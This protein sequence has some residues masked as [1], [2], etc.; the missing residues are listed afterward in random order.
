MNE[1]NRFVVKSLPSSGT[2]GYYRHNFKK[3][4]QGSRLTVP[5]LTMVF[6]FFTFCGRPDLVYFEHSFSI[7]L[8]HKSVMSFKAISLTA[9]WRGRSEQAVGSETGDSKTHMWVLSSTAPRANEAVGTIIFLD[10]K[11]SSRASK[12]VPQVKVFP[13]R[14]EELIVD[15]RSRKPMGESFLLT[16]TPTTRCAPY[17]QAHCTHISNVVKVQVV[18]I[19]G[20]DDGSVKERPA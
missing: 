2:I 20:G 18:T 10:I 3:K 4:H 12:M 13:R 15:P 16:C 19:G 5:P 17:Q 14:S 9:S 1:L 6:Y 7:T 8:S 11:S